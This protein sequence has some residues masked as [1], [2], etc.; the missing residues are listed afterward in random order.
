MQFAAASV[1]PF[2]HVEHKHKLLKVIQLKSAIHTE[3]SV[4]NRICKILLL[5]I[6]TEI[7]NVSPDLL[8]V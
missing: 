4:C 5:Y 3:S 2:E 6:I 8:Y 7:I 1:Y